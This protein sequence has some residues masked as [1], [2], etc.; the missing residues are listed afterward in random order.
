M[1]CGSEC[2]K[3][4]VGAAEVDGVDNCVE[5][6]GSGC[7]GLKSWSIGTASEGI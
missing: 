5:P 4:G 6:S 1:G 2:E 3:F 7:D